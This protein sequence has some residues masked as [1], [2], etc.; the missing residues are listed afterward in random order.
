MQGF[1]IS[2]HHKSRVSYRGLKFIAVF[3][4]RTTGLHAEETGL[5][6]IHKTDIFCKNSH[7]MSI[8]FE[9]LGF[10]S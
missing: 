9:K 5:Q 6:N 8:A 2:N 1:Y 10:F 3:T 7:S 4:P